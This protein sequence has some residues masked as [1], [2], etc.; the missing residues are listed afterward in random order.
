MLRKRMRDV[1]DEVHTIR[2]DM[3]AISGDANNLNKTI[4]AIYDKLC[5]TAEPFSQSQRKR[6]GSS[7]SN[8]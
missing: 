1:K 6:S 3:L 2:E 4:S 7:L 5:T 8:S